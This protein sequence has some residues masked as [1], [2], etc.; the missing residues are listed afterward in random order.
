MITIY[1][2]IYFV[3]DVLIAILSI[4]AIIMLFTKH[5][6]MHFFCCSGLTLLYGISAAMYPVLNMSKFSLANNICLGLIWAFMTFLDVRDNNTEK[7]EEFE[8]D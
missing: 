4:W 5:K 3:F 2:K 6:T 7:Q 1:D 8:S